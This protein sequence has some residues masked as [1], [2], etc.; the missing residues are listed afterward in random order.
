M[1]TA[2]CTAAEVEMEVREWLRNAADREGGRKKR[3][4]KKRARELAAN[5]NN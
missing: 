3:E 5:E 1:K 2:K 4:A